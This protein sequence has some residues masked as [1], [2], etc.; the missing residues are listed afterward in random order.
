MVIKFYNH[1]MTNDG[2]VC[3]RA[4]YET[5]TS[6]LNVLC[7]SRT[8]NLVSIKNE[9]FSLLILS[10]KQ[11]IQY[12][13][14]LGKLGIFAMQDNPICYLTINW[15]IIFNLNQKLKFVIYVRHL[16]R[17]FFSII[18]IFIK[19]REMRVSLSLNYVIFYKSADFKEGVT[20]LR[21]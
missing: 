5:W 8:E 11:I 14:T 19:L 3:S 4:E 13:L 15:D 16:W 10:P 1:D 21:C 18:H 7:W 12:V 17:Q 2:T 6:L 20:S 9:I